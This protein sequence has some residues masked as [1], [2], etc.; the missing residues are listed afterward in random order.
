MR[1]W[2]TY[3]N[4]NSRAIWDLERLSRHRAAKLGYRVH[5]SRRRKGRDN[6]LV[7]S[8]WSTREARPCCWARDSQRHW[9]QFSNSWTGSGC[10]EAP[11]GAKH[12]RRSSRTRHSHNHAS[13]YRAPAAPSS[14]ATSR[15]KVSGRIS[16]IGRRLYSHSRGQVRC[17]HE[18]HRRMPHRVH[19][20]GQILPEDGLRPAIRV[21]AMAIL[22]RLE[23]TISNGCRN[24]AQVE[25]F[26]RLGHGGSQIVRVEHMYVNEGGQAIIG[27]VQRGVAG[28]GELSRTHNLSQHEK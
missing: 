2:Q 9:S 18:A 16:G 28:D 6:T 26:R 25:A 15:R 21:V 24:V 19:A 17:I 20:I 5:R 12:F 13:S 22:S 7:I 8:C 4:G 10:N 27:N 1:D 3:R 11:A 14:H 23:G